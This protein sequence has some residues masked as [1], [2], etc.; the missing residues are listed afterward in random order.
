MATSIIDLNTKLVAIYCNGGK[1]HLFRVRNDVTFSGDTRRV[2]DVE[3]RH[4]SISSIRVVQFSQMKLMNDNDVRTM[5]SIFGQCSTK[6]PIELN[7]SFVRTFNDI[8]KSL[9]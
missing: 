4:P 9:I 5:F 7:T 1:P 8:H 6:C 3:Y 2:D